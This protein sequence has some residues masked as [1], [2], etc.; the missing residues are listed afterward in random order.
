MAKEHHKHQGV[1][2]IKVNLFKKV[3]EVDDLPLWLAI[4]PCGGRLSFLGGEFALV[5]LPLLR[6]NAGQ[7]KK[8]LVT[9]QR[10]QSAPTDGLR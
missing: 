5:V 4:V 3:F 2:K 8:R 1:V 7:P 6:L 10:G 9:T